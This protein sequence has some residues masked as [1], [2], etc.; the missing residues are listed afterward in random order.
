MKGQLR[1][2]KEMESVR[3]AGLAEAWRLI[4][5]NLKIR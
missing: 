2:E 1:R 3:S 5:G 4:V